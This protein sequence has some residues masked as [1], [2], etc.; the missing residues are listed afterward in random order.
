MIM[1]GNKAMFKDGGGCRFVGRFLFV[2]FLIAL[3]SCQSSSPTDALAI[4]SGAPA[5]TPAAVAGN[6]EIIGAGQTR[7]AIIMATNA[8]SA[9]QVKEIRNGAELALKDLDNGGMSI[10]L[11]PVGAGGAALDE[12]AVEAFVKG[13]AVIAYAGSAPSTGVGS[14]A[15]QI[16]LLPNGTARPKGSLTFMPTAADSLEAGIR[17][18]LAGKKGVTIL[19]PKGQVLPDL[20]AAVARLKAD[21]P[22]Q[23]IEYTESDSARSIA[24]KAAA[25]PNAVY[26]F[27]GNGPEIPAIAG[28]ISG[29]LGQQAAIQFVGNTNWSS[30]PILASPALEGAIVAKPDFSNEK[31]IS[32]NYRKAYGQMPGATSLYA[33]DLVAILAGVTR[34][35]GR[36]GLSDGT[37]KSKAG[38]RGVTGA[39]RFR[40]DGSVER[41]FAIQQIKAGKLV[42]M[43]GISSGF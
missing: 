38:F 14:S 8:L 40:N 16:A 29:K 24:A 25:T 6:A 17:Q 42:G 22:L 36:E 19:K 10:E 37:L 35:R 30:S 18:A 4:N 11:M 5:S 43:G 3:Q 15:L 34:A 41:I 20:S 1:R 9:V 33:Y 32:E 7:L 39:F 21:A 28:A 31:I 2:P 12:K 13:A 27:S 26:A 23:L